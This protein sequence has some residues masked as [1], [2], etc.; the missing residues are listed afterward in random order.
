M[1][2]SD[3]IGHAECKGA[4]ASDLSKVNVI[5]HAFRHVGEERVRLNSNN[6]K[7]N[8]A[9]RNRWTVNV[10]QTYGGLTNNDHVKQLRDDARCTNKDGDGCR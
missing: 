1:L 2:E 7:E 3:G 9:G 4:K 5:I 8:D 6:D 10:R